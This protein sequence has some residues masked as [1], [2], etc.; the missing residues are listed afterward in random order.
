MNP[1]VV[2]KKKHRARRE[3]NATTRQPRGR[4]CRYQTK[5]LAVCPGKIFHTY[6]GH[7]LQV[8][9]EINLVYETGDI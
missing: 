9:L 6:Q 5:C 4:K 1:E 3:K 8:F 7:T 2:M